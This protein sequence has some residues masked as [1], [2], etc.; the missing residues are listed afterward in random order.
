MVMLD[1]LYMIIVWNNCIEP[2]L[3]YSKCVMDK[4]SDN[5][6]EVYRPTSLWNGDSLEENSKI[7]GE[8]KSTVKGGREDND[9]NKEICFIF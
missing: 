7:S 2:N 5:E 8:K 6:I 3:L 4:C 9:N 1:K